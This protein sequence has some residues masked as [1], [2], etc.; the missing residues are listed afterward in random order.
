MAKI[1]VLLNAHVILGHRGDLALVA[2]AEHGVDLVEQADDI[3]DLILHLLPGHEDVR[4]VLR[5]AADAEE[6][7]QRAGKLVA[8]NKAQLA[9]TQ[10]QIAVGVRL[11]FVN[12]HAS[13]AVHGLYRIVLAVDDGGVHVLL[14]V[15]PV[16]GALP[17]RA[18][19]DH[20][21]GDLH[22]AVAFVY[23]TPVVNERVAQHSMPFGRKNGKPGPSSMSVK[24]PSSLPS[25]R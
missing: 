24:R 9:H 17:Q 7:V 11:G 15:L 18:V 13:R 16:A 2:Q 22:I 5:E 4:V 25:L 6:A 3:L 14:I 21:R 19:E 23:L 20:R 8:V 12:E 10:G 1:P